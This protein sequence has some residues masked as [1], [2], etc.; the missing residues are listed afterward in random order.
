VPHF[1][2][3]T[4][5]GQALGPVDLAGRDR[6]V[7]SVIYTRPDEPNPRVVDVRPADNTERQFTVLVVELVE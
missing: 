4:T 2:L 7:G 3:V 5:D 6:P 1:Q